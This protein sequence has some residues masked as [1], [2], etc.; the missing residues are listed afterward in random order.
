[1]P[2]IDYFWVDIRKEGREIAIFVPY[3]IDFVTLT[4]PPPPPPPSTH[5][6]PQTP[7]T[8]PTPHTHTHTHPPPLAPNL[9]DDIFNRT[10]LDENVWI[11]NKISLNVFPK[12]PTDNK[13]ALVQVMPWRD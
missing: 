11:L 8:H 13:L 6:H 7:H 9:T 5:T 2:K 1:M 3:G 12:G 10:L 4:P